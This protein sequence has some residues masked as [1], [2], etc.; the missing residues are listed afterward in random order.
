MP[1]VL[2]RESNHKTPVFYIYKDI[3]IPPITSSDINAK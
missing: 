2:H 1:F 3:T